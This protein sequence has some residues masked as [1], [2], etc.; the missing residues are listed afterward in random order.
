MAS[1]AE[2]KKKLEKLIQLKALKERKATESSRIANVARPIE[3]NDS[4]LDKV[5]GGVVGAGEVAG[6]AATALPAKIAGGIG[7]L[8]AAPFVG[9]EGAKNISQSISSA[10]GIPVETEE[11]QEILKFLGSQ[12]G[13]KQ[14]SDF[15]SKASK[16]GIEVGSMVDEATGSP[17]LGSIVSGAGGGLSEIAEVLSLKGLGRVNAPVLPSPDIPRVVEPEAIRVEPTLDAKPD[18]KPV[19]TDELIEKAKALGVTAEQLALA[20]PA[21]VQSIERSLGQADTIKAVESATQSGI[22]KGKAREQGVEDVAQQVKPDP[23]IVATAGRLGV[24]LADIPENVL[25][26]NPDFRAV[27]GALQSVPASPA[28]TKKKNLLISRAAEAEKTLKKFGAELDTGAVG[29]NLRNKM[30]KDIDN[31]KEVETT[32]Y[33]TDL[34][35]AVS[36]GSGQKN[37]II[38]PKITQNA[39]NSRINSVGGKEFLTSLESDILR[40]LDPRSKPTWARLDDLR[41]ELNSAK[42]NQGAFKDMDGGEIDLY[43][44]LVRADQKAISDTFGAGEIFETAMA[45]TS[46]RK[47]IEKDSQALFGKNLDKSLRKI[48]GK[49]LKDLSKG[50]VLEYNKTL[51]AIPK[52]NR[53]NVVLNSVADQ[54]INFSNQDKFIESAKFSQWWNQLKKNESAFT[55]FKRDLPDDVIQYIDDEAKLSSAIK[56][57]GED[58]IATGRINSLSEAF[59]AKDRAMEILVNGG[60]TLATTG[61]GIL[62][63]F[64]ASSVMREVLK[65][66][67]KGVNTSDKAQAVMASPQFQNL[68]KEI[69]LNASKPDADKVAVRLERLP[70]WKRYAESL[71]ISGQ[72]QLES[73][74]IVEFLKQGQEEE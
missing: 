40:R 35:Q 49:N 9:D 64:E 14:L 18:G 61:A 38:S 55:A 11:G 68:V 67:A 28:A 24:D 44:S 74:G 58:F 71:D 37:P 52:E 32:V 65:G 50:D 36:E 54:L 29:L 6:A 43:A 17:L 1:L 15:L 19:I 66:K 30:L 41:K 69:A 2:K 62:G 45:A 48:M 10:L 42:K 7:G 4:V 46:A 27:F 25:S 3:D 70:V 26:D 63:G 72:N 73:L 23:E 16:G 21:Q 47:K 59:Q 60:K 51:A 56:R 34:K 8:V 57:A 20:T 31:L 13:L 53:A 39:I 22:L 33:N 12:Q 5:V